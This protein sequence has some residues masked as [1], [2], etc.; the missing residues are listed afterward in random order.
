MNRF[1]IIFYLFVSCSMASAQKGDTVRKYLNDKFQITDKKSMVYEALAIKENDHWYLTA[2]YPDGGGL[3]FKI[4]FKDK[5]LTINDGPRIIYHPHNIKS[6][7]LIFRDNVA[8]GTYQSWYENANLKDSGNYTRGRKNGP[9]KSWYDSGSPESAGSYNNNQPDGEWDWYYENG[10][11]STKEIYS[12]GKIIK[13]ECYNENGEFTGE[14][15]GIARLPVPLGNFTTLDTYLQE[16]IKWSKEMVN[17]LYTGTWTVKVR[18]TITKDGQLTGFTVLQS[19]NEAFSREAERLLGLVQKWSPCISHNRP[20]D[21]VM[22]Y[23]IPFS[24]Q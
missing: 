18:F 17:G 1:F 11:P 2:T 8:E 4:Y 20:V 13:L 12:K 9:W 10:K 22:E 24:R 15:C 3:L 14:D 16:N 7:E 6:E 19:P 21:H 23:E 5:S